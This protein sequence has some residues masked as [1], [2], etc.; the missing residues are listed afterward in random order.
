MEPDPFKIEDMGFVNSFDHIG[1]H[2][3]EPWRQASF[4]KVDK[5]K[6]G[7]SEKKCEM[8]EWVSLHWKGY[9]PDGKLIFNSKKINNGRPM[10]FTLG[11]YEVSK[12]WDI[13]I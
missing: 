6:D 13:A 7:A 2:A 1:H 11:H 9:N 4:I 10:H 12:C 8:N 5:V 3:G